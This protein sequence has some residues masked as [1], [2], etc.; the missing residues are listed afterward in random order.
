M[1]ELYECLNARFERDMQD[2]ALELELESQLLE[3]RFNDY[4][5]NLLAKLKCGEQEQ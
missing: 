3:D 1:N 2:I 4:C 5:Q